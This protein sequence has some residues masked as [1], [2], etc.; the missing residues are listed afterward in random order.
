MDFVDAE[1]KEFKEMRVG[2]LAIERLTRG[3]RFKKGGGG[4][5]EIE[6]E[7]IDRARERER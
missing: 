2:P 5:R 3:S 6:R 1:C 7:V 4:Q